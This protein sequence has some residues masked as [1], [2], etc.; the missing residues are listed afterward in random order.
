MTQFSL[1]GAAAATPVL[2]DLG[3]VLLAGGH[4]VR[5][6]GTARL[7]IVVADR[8]RADALAEEFALRAVPGDVVESAEGWSART[9]F[10][11][12]LL[13]H[14]DRW[15]RG[16]IEGPPPGFEL[17]AAGLRLWTI[18]AGRVD[19]VGFLLGTG[20]ADTAL[21]LAAGAQL[22]RHGSRGGL[23]QSTARPRLAGQL[24]QADPP[25]R[26]VGGPRAGGLRS[27]LATGALTQVTVRLLSSCTVRDWRCVTACD[28]VDGSFCGRQVGQGGHQTGDRRV[29]REGEDHRGLPRS[30]LR[31]R[32]VDRPYPRPAPQRRGR[33]REVQGPALGARRRRH[34]E[35]LRADL[36]RQPRPQAAGHQ[37]QGPGQ[38]RRRGLPRHR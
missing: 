11:T 26:R 25:L 17:T 14:A 5:T 38:G 34:R 28:Q 36:R 1:F 7:S 16:A 20:R 8:W 35:R 10:S 32:G 24:A 12:A 13:P 18:A 15:N 31:R 27:A 19:E 4:W 30:G 2:E 29:A 22:A 6:G 37:A 3:G 23:A 21:H 33:A 9:A